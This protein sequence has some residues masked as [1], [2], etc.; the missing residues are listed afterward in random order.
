MV[1]LNRISLSTPYLAKYAVPWRQIPR[2]TCTQPQF[3]TASGHAN[4]QQLL[5]APKRHLLDASNQ[6]HVVESGCDAIAPSRRQAHLRRTPFVRHPWAQANQVGDYG[7]NGPGPRKSHC[8]SCPD[9]STRCPE[10]QPLSTEP[11]I[12][13]KARRRVLA[14]PVLVETQLGQTPTDDRTPRQAASRALVVNS[15]PQ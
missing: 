11:I 10:D 14:V 13:M 15:S 8:C 7:P 2:E 5:S 3:H 9:R 6:H 12:S 1:T 4:L